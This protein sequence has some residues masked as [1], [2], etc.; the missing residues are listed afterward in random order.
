MLLTEDF[1]DNIDDKDIV[2]AGPSTPVVVMGLTKVPEAG[3]T[4]YE[5]DEES[6]SEENEEETK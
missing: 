3:E 4:F 5:V 1:L 6:E 2:S